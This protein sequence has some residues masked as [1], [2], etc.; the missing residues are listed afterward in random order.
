MAGRPLP[1]ALLAGFAFALVL[2]WF[3]GHGSAVQ[4]GPAAPVTITLAQP[5]GTIFQAKPYGD[6]WANGYETLEGYTILLDEQTGVWHYA[7]R[8]EGGQ[9]VPSAARPGLERPPQDVAKHLRTPIQGRRNPAAMVQS[10]SAAHLGRSGTERVL[11][12]LVE[13]SDTQHLGSTAA[14]WSTAAFGAT[15]S[16]KHYYEEVSY[17]KLHLMPAS[18]SHGTANDGIIGWLN[19]GYPHPNTRGQTGDATRD[20]ARRALQAADPYINF[21]SFD[22]N[23]DG[24]LSSAELHIVVIVAGYETSF[25][26]NNSCQPGVWAHNWFLY[27]SVPAP[28][29][30]GVYVA[31]PTRGGS[32]CMVGE[33]LQ[34]QNCGNPTAGHMMTIGQ[35]S[36]ELGHSLGMPDLYDTDSNYGG[37]NDPSYGVGSFSLMAAGAWLRTDGWPGS[38]P[39]HLDP[40]LKWYQGW[41]TPTQLRSSVARYALQAVETSGQVVQLLDNPNGVDWVWFAPSPGTGEY[42]LVENR[43]KVGYDAGLP[44]CG[45]LIWHID[46]TRRTDNFANA[47]EARKLVDLEE[48]DGLAQ[49]DDT[50]SLGDAGDFFPGTSNNRRFDDDSNPNARL[51]SG[52]RSRVAVKNISNCANSMTADFILNGVEPTVVPTGTVGPQTRKVYLPAILKAGATPPPTTRTA[53]PTITAGVT[54]TPTPTATT[55]PGGW[56]TIIHEGFEGS[57][58]GAWEVA[59]EGGAG[60]YTWGKRNCRPFAGSFSGWAVGG[61]ANGQSLACGSVYPNERESWLVYGPF[62]LAGATAAEVTFKFWLNT[63]YEYDYFYVLASTDGTNFDGGG[64]ATGNSQGW[65]DG[66]LDLANVEGLGNLLGRSQ[67]WIAFLFTSDGSEGLAEGAYVD[68]ITLRKYV[69]AGGPPASTGTAWPDSL[70]VGPVHRVLRR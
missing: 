32:Y 51:Y 46:E 24:Y 42:F 45:L 23:R 55:Q 31:D 66:R 3:L 22:T 57:F 63:E 30:D 60:E 35:V 20:I 61:G 7:I 6:E 49:L 5:D 27:E 4:A 37:D 62:S 29:L 67:V 1:R 68:E 69:G 9:L 21:A 65:R 2:I 16:I 39:A 58:P 44:G 40:F 10:L 28:R 59:D 54:A 17:N 8:G 33:W 70:K 52:A 47:F 12:I 36:H 18:E 38:S 41:I 14:Q 34:T 13:F 26:G 48:A 64:W 56:V 50:S 19:L 15:N 43:Q 25:G 53:T 11:V